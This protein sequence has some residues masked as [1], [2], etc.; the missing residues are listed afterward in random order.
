MSTHTS[1][2]AEPPIKCIL[3]KGKL[4]AT[5][6]T[7]HREDKHNKEERPERWLTGKCVHTHSIIN[8]EN[9]QSIILDSARWLSD[10][11]THAAK[12]GSVSATMG[13]RRNLK[14]LMPTVM[15]P[16]PHKKRANHIGLAVSLLYSSKNT[17]PATVFD[18]I[19][20]DL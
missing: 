12:N 2:F 19:K 9:S 3:R 1:A 10:F 4:L 17:K 13:S 16:T 11:E 7:T 8:D 5:V 14:R 18:T 20:S 6:Q 15:L